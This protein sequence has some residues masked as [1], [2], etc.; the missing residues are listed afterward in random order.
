MARKTVRTIPQERSPM[1]IQDPGVRAENFDEVAL[2]F[3]EADAVV[4]GER[5]LVCPAPE[6]VSACPVNIDIPGFIVKITE[7]DYRGAYD[8][9]TDSTL[10]PAICGRVCPQE[11][12]CEGV[13][14][15][16]DT[17]EPVAIG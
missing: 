16:G 14:P 13:C 1:P 17:L 9:L 8:I 4:E 7:K 3:R 10:L 12:L 15:V 11:D 5:C 2:G 6:C